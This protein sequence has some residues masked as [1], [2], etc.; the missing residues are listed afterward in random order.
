MVDP[1][2]FKFDVMEFIQKMLDDSDA[3]VATFA[4]E[5]LHRL[6]EFDESRGDIPSEIKCQMVLAVLN[7]TAITL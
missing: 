3:K 6:I 4:V 5:S 2:H 7:R 1:K